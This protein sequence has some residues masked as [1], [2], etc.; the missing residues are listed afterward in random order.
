MFNMKNLFLRALLALSIAI[1]APAALAGPVYHVSLDTSSLSGTGYLDLGFNGLGDGT[2]TALATITNFSGDFLTDAQ[3]NGDVSGGIAGGVLLGN[4]TGFN[5]FDQAISL[6]GL[7]SFDVSFETA[8]SGPGALFSV[9]LMND[10]F[11]AYLGGDFNLLTI[12]L[13]PGETALIDVLEP[14][15]ASIAQVAEVPEPGEWLLLATGLMLI[16]M[17]RRMR[18]RG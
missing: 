11:D 15:L 13:V 16:A 5:F 12:D 18:Q 4:A 10:T 14:G 2:R 17:T 6:G 7:F 9:A 3:P 1:G 8:A